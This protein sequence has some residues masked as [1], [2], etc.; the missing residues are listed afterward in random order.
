MLILILAWNYELLMIKGMAAR[1]QGRA[2]DQPADK[3]SDKDQAV[4]GFG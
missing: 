4:P 3:Y 2:A 1:T